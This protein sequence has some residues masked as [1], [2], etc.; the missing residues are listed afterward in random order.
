MHPTR[1]RLS[2]SVCANSWHAGVRV[3]GVCVGVRRMKPSVSVHV[4]LRKWVVFAFVGLKLLTDCTHHGACNHF[5]GWFDGD[6]VKPAEPVVDMHDG[7]D[8]D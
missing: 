1:E 7:G 5:V 6:H 8:G 2:R 3:E 4:S